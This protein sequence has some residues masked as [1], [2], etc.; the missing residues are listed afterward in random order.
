VQALQKPKLFVPNAFTPEAESNNVFMPYGVFVDGS[1]YVF[2]IYNRWGQVIFE[3]ND[4]YEG[5]NG[6]VDGTIAT[7]G[8]YV[9]FIKFKN[10]KG[11]MFEK[12]GTV[13]LLK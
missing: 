2:Q 7:E 6:M 5:W 13:T 4:L 11:E 8:V 12:R 9:Y 3:T 1:G 10:S